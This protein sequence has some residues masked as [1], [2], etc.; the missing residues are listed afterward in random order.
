MKKFLIFITGGIVGAVV[1]LAIPYLTSE[2]TDYY[3]NSITLL[4]E[5]GECVSTNNFKILQVT[6]GGALAL[7]LIDPN[8][9]ELDLPTALTDLLN[10]PSGLVVFFKD[11]TGAAYY[12]GQVIKMPKGMCAKQ[13]GVYR[14]ITTEEIEKTVPIVA[15]MKK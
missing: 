4:K 12:D 3:T 7:E 9:E 6:D 15:I 10:L 8:F 11:D 13:I 2:E 1:A 14:Y 5:A